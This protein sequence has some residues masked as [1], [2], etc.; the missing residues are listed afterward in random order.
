M[1]RLKGFSRFRFV[2]ATFC[3][4]VGVPSTAAM[5]QLATIFPGMTTV[6][7]G[8]QTLPIAVTLKTGGTIASVRVM[9][10]GKVNG[11]YTA[12]TGD[13]C[14]GQTIGA[15]Q[16]CTVTIQF[17]PTAPGE[18]R[19]AVLLLDS[20]GGLL[21]TQT[22]Y[23]IGLGSMGILM[24]GTMET[25]AGVSGVPFYKRDGIPAVDA[26]IYLPQGVAVDALG[27]IFL[28][29]TGNNRV[30]RVDAQTGLISTVA[31]V[32]GS[33]LTGDNGPATSAELSAPA[34]MIIDG[35]GDI[36]FSDSGNDA[37]R[38]IN[39]AT[40]IITTVAGQLGAAGFG[41]D[42]GPATAALMNSPE[43]LALNARGDLFISDLNNAR[44]RKV[45]AVTGF[46][47]TVVG[48][49]H[50]GT[51]GDGGP[52]LAAQLTLPYGIAMNVAG[53]L[54]IADLGTNTVREMNAAGIMST[55]AGTGSASNPTDGM[56]GTSTPMRGPQD[57][58]VDVAGNL[59]IA[60]TGNNLI[61]K[62]SA[63]TGLVTAVA[64]NGSTFIGGDGGPALQAG[65]QRPYAMA[66]DSRGNLI[67]ADT[68][69]DRLREVQNSLSSLKYNA[70]KVGG[71]SPSQQVTVAN[72]GNA[73]LNFSAI[74]PD[75]N[76]AVDATK[77]TCST[78][79]PVT[80]DS[81]CVIAA[82]FAPLVPGT[83]VTAT[84]QVQSDAAN[85]PGVIALTGESDTLEP[86]TTTLTSDVNPV[87]FGATVTFTAVISSDARAPVGNVKFYDGTVLLGTMA[88]GATG[89]TA[90][91]SVS[92]LA[93][94]AH[95]I[96]ATFT[97]D[98]TNSPST[99]DALTEVVKQ[100]STVALSS[101][102]TPAKVGQSITF[103]AT[104]TGSS[105]MPGGLVTF[106]DGATAIGTGGLNSS[107]VASFSTSLLT[108]GTHAITAAYAGDTSTLPGT[109]AILSQ[110]VNLWSTST[111]LSSSNPTDVLGAPLVFSVHVA[112][113]ST[114]APT[115]ALVL[116]DGGTTIATLAV[117]GSGNAS[118]SS[119]SLAVGTHTLVA[120][121][122]ADAT[123]DTSSSAPLAQVVQT[124]GTSTVLT[125]SANP[126]SAG[127]TLYLSATVSAATNATA[128]ALTGTVT[129]KDGAITLGT[130][131]I[132]ATGVATLDVASLGVST[133]T[134]VAVYG[135]ITNYAPSTSN[136][137]NEVVQLAT[138]SVQIT[139]SSNPSI[140]GKGV[141]LTAVVSG[142]GGIPG[143]TVTFL[144]GAATLGTATV[145]GSGQATL[146]LSS[147]PTGTLSLTAAY[148]G[149]AKD[150][151]STS[152][153][154]TQV[155]QQTTTAITLTSS[156]NP[157]F[158][159]A[160]V[161][162]VASLTSNGSVPSGQL[163][164][165]EGS[166]VIASG[167]MSGTGVASFSVNSL[168]AGSHT[169]IAS[170]AGDVD[171]AAST[172]SALVQV[173]Q[174]GTSVTTITSSKNPSVFGDQV[175]IN[176]KV[177]GTAL[178]PAGTVTLMDQGAAVA[179][180]T[181]N[182]S[183]LA[184]YP[185]STLAIGDHS[186]TA[187][188]SGDT[189]HAGST[190]AVLTQRVQEA[191][192]TT[193]LSSENPSLVGDAV[194]LTAAVVGTN[195]AAVTGTVSFTDGSAVIGSGPVT[196]G[197]VSIS[198]STLVAGTHLIVANYAGDAT[199]V[200]SASAALSQVVSAAGT[201]VMLSSSAN[202]SVTGTAVVF[203]AAVTSKGENATGSVTFLDG[204]TT[205]GTGTVIKG[206]ATFT[207]S[208][209][210][211]GQHA[212]VARYGGDSG[213]QVSVS[214]AIVQV[215]Q[216]KTGISL[217]SS[218]N[219][220]LTLQSIVLTAR[221][222]NGANITGV[223][224][225]TDSDTQI[226]SVN[227]GSDGTAVLSLPSL[228]AG[229]HSLVASYGGD[230]YNLPSTAAALTETVQLRTTTT[231]LAVSSN[232][233]LSGQ[234]ITL[235]D[236]V[237]ADGPVAPTGTVTFMSGTNT[238]GTAP[239][240]TG[241]VALLTFFP[242]DPSYT[243]VAT[244]SGDAAYA[245]SATDKSTITGGPSTTFTMI[246]NPSAMSLARGSHTT[247]NLTMTSVKNFADTISLG[248]L[249]LPVD[250][251]CTFSTDKA[252]LAANG[253]NVVQLT[254]DTGNP[255]GVGT[256]A[257]AK[258]MSLFPDVSGP[259]EAGLVIPAA[260]LLGG[261]IGWGRRRRTLPRLLS[262]IVLIGMG[263]GLTS[264][265]NQLTQ[266]K[267]PAGSY[268]IRIVASGV[269]T[270]ASEISDLSLTVTQ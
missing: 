185:T 167:A 225:F 74:L 184:N 130:A 237:R 77:T 214:N 228:S 162:F 205:L 55:V 138:T 82:E 257:K 50:P 103:S 69:D 208:G 101:N 95:T 112:I 71:T 23:G 24:Q 136:M 86:T 202:P 26:Q 9:T 262:L 149:D 209:L 176:F 261:L 156:A 128:G 131:N 256:S 72:D 196:N 231:T 4:L 140:S 67:I 88:T 17:K 255:L 3:A 60:D 117:D 212:I 110:A 13:T 116:T 243:I 66:L 221:V 147:L 200:A 29:D 102:L 85:S 229:N 152:T 127:A 99:S 15:N 1:N 122:Q 106:N 54:Y 177:T 28:S 163:T 161:T 79:T 246:A 173:V 213:T 31:G 12:V 211:A 18:R 191:T 224:T 265:A 153:T 107:G 52:G 81:T 143:G 259:M 190:S 33:G 125:S 158:A 44:V 11:D 78:T 56:P 197:A 250:A 68:Y 49:G 164:F 113:T 201:T 108:A 39:L 179:T 181:L 45:D 73:D 132:S 244:Y 174:T 34:A 109:S 25:V 186:L 126:V 115:G 21:G 104:V 36:I 267:T 70:I 155:V 2:L 83:P 121:Y 43:G 35:A 111:T 189:T 120:I 264:C 133:H 169:L 193:L 42:G 84:I 230:S 268:T 217:A 241:G 233:Y 58:K 182:A 148:G 247:I 226:G 91:F 218:L 75:G 166:T 195:G 89:S 5:A 194:K 139:S 57:V 269:Q 30:R 239:V 253:T 260:L 170:F 14:T 123:N 92:T 206:I 41:G 10:Q 118:Y 220:A 134:I 154:L 146:S 62:L 135:G 48:T 160:A 32:S 266:N 59:Y 219:P 97:G 93:L 105:S 27:N 94:G 270:G 183:G 16:S 171:H 141:T 168:T 98:A 235:I 53:D 137:V 238:L 129:F 198:V 19:G 100:T 187:V 51:I 165:S 37:V 210:A 222:T 204:S 80:A 245:G 248:C 61:Q 65:I 142:S 175:V 8:T 240:S 144:N 40:G 6:T 251:T 227:I 114:V 252:T 180:I 188:Y 192:T 46:I 178:Q 157:S 203:S 7:T 249:G 258:R 223:V 159:G 207:T 151:P 215:V 145:G 63:T 90:K 124:I 172:S 150:N 96:T 76:S 254:I 22:M 232:T 20:N 216:N 38:R 236:V 199:N 119:S 87:G 47:S 234:Q 263:M 242:V 64:G